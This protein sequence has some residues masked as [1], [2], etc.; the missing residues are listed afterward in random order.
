MSSKRVKVILDTNLWI[1]F[2]ISRN[3]SQLDSRIK[4]G[5]VQLIFSDESLSEFLTVASRPAFQKYFS[6]ED[7][8][9]IIEYIDS[10][11]IIVE[12][13]SKVNLCRDSKDNFLLALAKDS[14]ADYLVTGDK[15]L[16]SLKSFNNTLI[17]TFQQF[18]KA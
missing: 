17:I 5:T 12:V 9:R 15:D 4:K 18:L 11:G 14:H 8:L 6:N 13:K 3:L 2:L 7:I 1:S 16:L 10:E